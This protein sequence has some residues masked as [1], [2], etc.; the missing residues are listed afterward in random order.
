[1]VELIKLK[2]KEVGLSRLVAGYAW[3]WESQNNPDKE[4]FDIDIDGVKLRWNSTNTDWINSE[5]AITEV[6]CIH[7]T[8]GYDLNYV[9]VI[10][11]TEITYDKIK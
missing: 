1:M 9:G 7:T 5:N 6:G 11:G 8:Q 2:D 3:E 4:V 10:F